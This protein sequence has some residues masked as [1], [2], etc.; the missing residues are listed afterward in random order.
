M[1]WIK[2]I[3]S[4]YCIAAERGDAVEDIWNAASRTGFQRSTPYTPVYSPTKEMT[5]VNSREG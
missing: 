2:K 1:Y 5:A 4:C 3:C